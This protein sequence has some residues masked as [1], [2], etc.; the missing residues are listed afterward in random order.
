M[1]DSNNPLDQIEVGQAQ[2]AVTANELF[3]AMSPA[4]LFGRRAITTSGLT[5]GYY[6]GRYQGLQID[7]GTTVLP[8]SQASVYI[9][10]AKLDGVVSD[11]TTSTNWDDTENYERLY[12]AT[13]GS[14]TITAWQDFR[15]WIS[16]AGGG[17]GF[18]VEQVQDIVG[19]LVVAGDG[20]T[21]TYDDAGSPATLTIEA[22]TGSL[23]TEGIQDIV[24]ALIVAGTGIDVTYDDAGSP[25]TITIETDGTAGVNVEQV[26]DIVGAL[27]VAGDNITL[28]YDDAG[29]PPTLT[30][31]SSG[32]GG[33]GYS[34]GAGVPAESPTPENGWRHFNTDDGILYTWSD[35]AGAWVE[36]GA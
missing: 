36:M 19:S 2:P 27:L 26:Q 35:Y 23:D 12:I 17:G 11:S 32:G 3:D 10:A 1:A 13:T 24:G 5:W 6:G 25:P 9:V 14:A 31:D 30:I 33:G 22:D 7:H 34:E 18:T 28:T 4:A 16:S 29:S 8:A 21:V 20:I 15:E